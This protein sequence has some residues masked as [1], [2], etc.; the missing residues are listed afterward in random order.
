M[1]SLV[2]MTASVFPRRAVAAPDRATG[3][4]HP[5]LDRARTVPL[6]SG[7]GDC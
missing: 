7:T 4:A 5:Q 1:A 2:V 6:A 3:E